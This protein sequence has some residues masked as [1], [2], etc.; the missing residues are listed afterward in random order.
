MSNNVIPLHRNLTTPADI[1]KDL[2]ADLDTIKHV[3][4]IMMDNTD[5]CQTAWSSMKLSEMTYLIRVMQLEIDRRIL[6]G[7]I[8]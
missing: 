4:V 5:C 6:A 3:I 8:E 7:A 2:V 1:A